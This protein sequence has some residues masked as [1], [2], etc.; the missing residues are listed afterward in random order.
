[1]SDRF[2]VHV[3]EESGPEFMFLI[4]P[5]RVLR[6]E[7]F[8]STGIAGDMFVRGIDRVDF[9]GLRIVST[10]VEGVNYT[11]FNVSRSSLCGEN[12]STKE[13]AIIKRMSPMAHKDSEGDRS[14]D[15]VGKKKAGNQENDE[16]Q[17]CGDDDIYRDDTLGNNENRFS[18]CEFLS[19]STAKEEMA[20]AA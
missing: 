2:F 1:M 20:T 8:Q 15:N 10:D 9:N 5:I 11:L 16:I 14:K 3:P 12:S 4:R 18:G 6:D 19:N 17:T 13:N 7:K